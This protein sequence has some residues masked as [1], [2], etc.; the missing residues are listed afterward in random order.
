M[1][2]S[3]RRR[4]GG[5]ERAPDNWERLVRAALKRDR[6]HLRV[7]GAPAAVGGQRLADAVP[8]SLGRTTNIEQIL[9]AADDI[10]DEDPNVARIREPLPPT[11]LYLFVCVR[12]VNNSAVHGWSWQLICLA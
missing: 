6:D 7:G 2:S 3:R 8:A 11:Y 1:A 5:P 12:L 10:E 4:G 9:Q